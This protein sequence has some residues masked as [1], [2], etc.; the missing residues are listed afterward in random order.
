M[1]RIRLYEIVGLAHHISTH[2]SSRPRLEVPK[3]PFANELSMR[4]RSF[5]VHQQPQLHI[6]PRKIY[7]MGFEGSLRKGKNPMQ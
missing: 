3:P 7:D 1:D 4:R 5:I 2:A 6:Y